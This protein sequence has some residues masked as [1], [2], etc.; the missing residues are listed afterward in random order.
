ML[1]AVMLTALVLAVPAAALA[2]GSLAGETTDN[3]VMDGDVLSADTPAL[4]FSDEY[5][6][7]EDGD[8]DA[9]VVSDDPVVSDPSEAIED[10]Q[11]TEEGTDN[12]ALNEDGDE[13]LDETVDEAVEDLAP[14]P[15]DDSETPEVSETLQAAVVPLPT[16]PASAT[17]ITEG[18]YVL[19]ATFAKLLLIEA[20]TS[21]AGAAVQ[22][23][24]YD[25]A[26][27]QRW[28]VQRYQDTNWYR[29]HLESNTALALGV[30]SSANGAAATAVKVTGDDQAETL[31]AFVPNSDGSLHLVSAANTAFALSVKGSSTKSG[32]ALVLATA[33]GTANQRVVLVSVKP[34]VKAGTKGLEGAYV[35]TEKKSG[36]AATIKGGKT[37]NGAN[38]ML[39]ANKGSASQQ[40][41]LEPVDGGG[42]YLVWIIGTRKVLTVE[43]GNLLSGA[44]VHQWKCKKSIT[45][46]W[47]AVKG[48]DGSVKLINRGTGL[49][50][51]AEGSSDGA[52]LAG[53]TKGSSFKLKRVALLKK[54][55]VEIKPRTASNVSVGV[56]K[57]STKNGASIEL[58]S[59]TNI[60]SQRFELIAAG[61]TDLWRLRTASSGGY[62]T[63]KDGSLSQ[64]GK[65]ATKAGKNNTWRVTFRGGWYGL[66]LNDGSE[67]AV[68]LTSGKTAKGTKFGVVKANGSDAQHLTFSAADLLKPGVY[69]IKN[70]R[71]KLLDVESNSSTP[72]ANVQ[73]FKK[74][75]KRLLGEY[76]SIEKAGSYVRIKNTYS[77]LCV[78]ARGKRNGSNVAMRNASTANS[79]KW[80]PQ[81]SDGG[82]VVFKGVGRYK[83]LAIHV[84]RSSAKN[85][86]N[87]VMGKLNDVA[88]QKWKLVATTY[89]PYTGYMLKALKKANA[90]NSATNY[91][92]VVDRANTH[93]MIMKRNGAEWKLHRSYLCSCGKSSTPTISGTYTVGS[94]GYQFTDDD[95]TCYYWT[96]IRGDYLFHSVL[97][98]AGTKKVLDGRLGYHISMGC[99]RLSI[100]NAKWIYDNI[101]SGTKIII[102]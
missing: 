6:Y 32:T 66:M 17:T 25:N 101:P 27:N 78:A 36:L 21:A 87:V 26:G 99:V 72:G 16:C 9:A 85:R 94:R 68:N 75:K 73:T 20:K 69:F 42:Y 55:I 98:R 8:D 77:E 29:L 39:S 64:Q 14:E 97:Y 88:G 58:Q 7:D 35:L 13:S 33:K 80:D 11:S 23:A 22:T 37:S 57:A 52:N 18:T 5:A 93:V 2:E 61:G 31:W 3:S 10:S 44:N 65:G 79:Q 28:V 45:Q 71:G 74:T 51:T 49:A 56:S 40:V 4:D 100:D 12:S 62:L 82:Y 96:E 38:L 15:T 76:F 46:K 95:H 1:L 83:K 92:M 89:N 30:S 84:S 24:S 86:A 50:L 81:I 19:Q 43:G 70:A 48:S 67:L 47:A 34:S 41:Y 53:T 90:N 54:G 91:L 59:D 63:A 60:L 102:Y